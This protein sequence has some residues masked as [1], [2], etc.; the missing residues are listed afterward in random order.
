VEAE[1]T[2]LKLPVARRQ[3]SYVLPRSNGVFH[4][5]VA[6]L[7]SEVKAQQM[8]TALAKRGHRTKVSVVEEGAHTWHCVRIGP[9]DTRPEAEG[10]GSLVEQPPGTQSV[11][12]PFGREASQSAAKKTALAQR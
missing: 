6:S 11:V 12:I 8:A 5:Q 9:F 3:N 4:V 1:T 7:E 10:Y 2:R